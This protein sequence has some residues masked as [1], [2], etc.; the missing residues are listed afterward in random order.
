MGLE[1]YQNN[2]LN[3]SFLTPQEMAG[4]LKVSLKTIYRMVESRSITF[5]KVGRSLRVKKA[6]VE[7]YLENTLV[8]SMPEK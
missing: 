6:D 3:Q 1:F 8:K 4:Y 2:E 5:Y 7:K